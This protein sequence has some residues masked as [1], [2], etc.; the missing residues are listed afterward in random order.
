[1]DGRMVRLSRLPELSH[2]GVGKKGHR[3]VGHLYEAAAQGKR[4]RC[5]WRSN[6]AYQGKPERRDYKIVNVVT[7]GD[8]ECDATA[9]PRL[10]LS[11]TL[12]GSSRGCSARR[13]Q[14]VSGRG[15]LRG[16]RNEAGFS[17]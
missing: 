6:H 8:R 14:S 15:Q 16:L 11:G 7:R 2:P 17:V 4:T 12:P 1:M 5:P 9:R 13:A 3:Y 10:N